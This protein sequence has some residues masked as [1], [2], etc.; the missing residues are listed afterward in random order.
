MLKKTDFLSSSLA[1]LEYG[2]ANIRVIKAGTHVRCAVTN[3]VIEIEALKYWSVEKQEP[4]ISP[5]AVF[6]SMG[7]SFTKKEG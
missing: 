2:D 3:E 4:Y 6:K 1:I 7:L 5:Q